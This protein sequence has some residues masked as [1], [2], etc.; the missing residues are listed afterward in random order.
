MSIQ[1]KLSK[2]REARKGDRMR[3]P[4]EVF[5]DDPTSRAKAI[6]A[7]CFECMGKSEGYI[8]HIREC[9]SKNCPLYNFRPYK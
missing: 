3:N 6:N 7:F 9:T 2:M 1:E 5:K 4:E 8:K